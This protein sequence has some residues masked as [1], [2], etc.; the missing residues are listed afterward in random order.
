MRC[1]E[2]PHRQCLLTFICTEQIIKTQHSFCD[3]LRSVVQIK[4]HSQ[5]YIKKPK[6][7]FAG[8][9]KRQRLDTND[10]ANQT[11]SERDA[12]KSVT[13]S[14]EVVK[15]QS[16]H[17]QYK[18]QK[19]P[20]LQG[21]QIVKTTA[22]PIPAAIV[23][24]REVD[25]VAT[26]NRQYFNHPGN[27]FYNNLVAASIE[28]MDSNVETNHLVDRILRIVCQDRGGAFLVE[29]QGTLT[30]MGSSDARLEVTLALARGR[31]ITDKGELRSANESP[32]PTQPLRAS[33]SQNRKKATP[34]AKSTIAYQAKEGSTTAIPKYTLSLISYMCNQIDPQEALT[35]LDMPLVKEE[36]DIQRQI[37]L[38]LRHRYIASLS[39]GITPRT[40]SRRLMHIWGGSVVQVR[41]KI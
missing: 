5:K 15:A 30:V 36:S 1:L 28:K 26:Q 14:M 18:C 19:V 32:E 33:H 37:R 7:S 4:S 24:P 25:V 34:S 41:R 17:Q 10:R 21:R 39:V 23:K 13:K 6:E 16:R 9:R 22:F 40:F 20:R 38:Q 31:R 35:A 3:I 11:A 29:R 8:S 12:V 27:L 2:S